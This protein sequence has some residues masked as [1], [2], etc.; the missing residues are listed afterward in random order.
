MAA[1]T[2]PIEQFFNQQANS[3]LIEE[4]NRYRTIPKDTYNVQ[5][6]KVEGKE[7]NY[8]DSGVRPGA[9]LT[10]KVS[11]GDKIIA[12][13]FPDVSWVE[14]RTKAGKL[15]RRSLLWGQLQKAAFSEATRA[16]MD[17]KTVE[18]V[19]E[20]IMKY[21]VGA[22]VTEAYLVPDPNNPQYTNSNTPR[23]EEEEKEYNERGYKKVNEILSF[24]KYQEGR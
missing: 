13:V 12:T 14:R 20:R 15:D 22:Y 4:A 18:D 5:V 21:P 10:V 11:K 24:N 9:H 1:N 6:V 2:V 7:W 16:D 19:I 8:K 23:S 17:A 3:T